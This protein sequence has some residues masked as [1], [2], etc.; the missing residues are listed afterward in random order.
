MVSRSRKALIK[1]AELRR[2]VGIIGAQGTDCKRGQLR[3]MGD[4]AA[5]YLSCVEVPLLV[6][7]DT[8]NLTT[9]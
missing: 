6:Q 4:E 7:E 9:R 3:T 5:R 2:Y 8:R 1:L